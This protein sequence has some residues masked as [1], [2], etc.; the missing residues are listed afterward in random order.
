MNLQ[1]VTSSS[2]DHYDE[3]YLNLLFDRSIYRPMCTHMG[4]IVIDILIV[5][6]LTMP[7]GVSIELEL[8]IKATK[9]PKHVHVTWCIF[10]GII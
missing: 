7:H 3:F 4:S 1:T 6:P 5:I 10:H 8:E 9:K 2:T